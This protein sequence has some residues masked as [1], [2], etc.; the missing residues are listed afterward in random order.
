V[1]FNLVLRTTSCRARLIKKFDLSSFFDGD[2]GTKKKCKL[3][4]NS[5][6]RM[7]KEKVQNEIEYRSPDAQT[8][9]LKLSMLINQQALEQAIE[10]RPLSRARPQART[11]KTRAT[12]DQFQS[13]KRAAPQDQKPNKRPKKLVMRKVG[14]DSDSGEPS[15]KKGAPKAG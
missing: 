14:K 8:S 5:L 12:L 3:L 11:G 1:T 9:V 2:K 7:L 15:G 10:D 13:K 4:V 6:P